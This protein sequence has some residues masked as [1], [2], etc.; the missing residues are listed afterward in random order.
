MT[1]Q[2]LNTLNR[3]INFIQLKLYDFSDKKINQE[4]IKQVFERA[5]IHYNKSY[6]LE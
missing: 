5:Q 6:I 3:N 4:K 1:K 2:I